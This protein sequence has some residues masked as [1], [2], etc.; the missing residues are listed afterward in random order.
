MRSI[1]FTIRP[2]VTPT[3]QSA[4]LNRVSKVPGLVWISWPFSLALMTVGGAVVVAIL[5]R[6]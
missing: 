6:C 5:I 4:V 3:E 1:T 2:H